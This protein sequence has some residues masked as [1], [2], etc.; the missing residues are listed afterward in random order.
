MADRSNSSI[1]RILK[2]DALPPS[3]ECK[4][5]LQKAEQSMREML[6]R[7]AHPRNSTY[8]NGS[9]T[10]G[11]VYRH[12]IF[13][14]HPLYNTN[15]TFGWSSLC[16]KWNISKKVLLP[17]PGGYSE[18]LRLLSL[19]SPADFHIDFALVGCKSSAQQQ[20]RLAG[21]FTYADMLMV[22]DE[23]LSWEEFQ[24]RGV[25]G[26]LRLAFTKL[27]GNLWTPDQLRSATIQSITVTEL[28]LV[29]GTKC[30]MLL[31]PVH[32]VKLHWAP[33]EL[34]LPTTASFILKDGC[35]QRVADC[36][37]SGAAFQS[38]FE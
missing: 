34:S 7:Q 19:W 29:E 27:A 20:L 21:L 2:T 24:V 30:W 32:Q 9:W 31:I 10:S 37:L 3:F 35:L 12:N 5:V 28:P 8:L 18:E 16:K 15:N 38:L 26:R 25:S 23:I 11:H 17:K 22:R 14:Q 4:I 1:G 33:G 13:S 36:P 6:L